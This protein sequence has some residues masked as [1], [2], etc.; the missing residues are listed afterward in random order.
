MHRARAL[1]LL[2][3]L[4]FAGVGVAGV[5]GVM[6]ARLRADRVGQGIRELERK[7]AAGRKEVDHLERE[8]ARAQDVLQLS[9]RVGEDLRPP[10]P[11]QVVWIRPPLSSLRPAAAAG[12]PT[13]P[14]MAALN[15]AAADP[16]G[17]GGPARR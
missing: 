13:S 12:S 10:E 5:I 15:A 4:A 6:Q 14:R 2:L 16:A 11:G 7:I 8:R 1:A 9:R 17:P 3:F